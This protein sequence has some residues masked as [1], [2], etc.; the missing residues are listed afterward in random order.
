MLAT[1][2]TAGAHK[3][4]HGP[5][6]E[7]APTQAIIKLATQY[8]GAEFWL[9]RRQRRTFHQPR[10]RRETLGELIQIDGSEH[11]WFEDRAEL[12]TS[13]V[14]IDD[15]TDRLMQLRFVPG[16]STQSYF[17]ALEGYLTTHGCP[18]PFYSDKHTMF[19]VAR[20]M[21]PPVRT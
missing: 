14:S 13:L 5:D 2:G 16:E 1:T 6:D 21:P 3:V 8:G 18:V 4:P 12:C 7:A 9:S 11:R 17:A 19:R 20:P 15:A 10:F